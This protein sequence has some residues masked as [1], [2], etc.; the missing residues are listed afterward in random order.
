MYG[1]SKSVEINHIPLCGTAVQGGGR[2][3]VSQSVLAILGISLCLLDNKCFWT[4]EMRWCKTTAARSLQGSMTSEKCC[5]R[6]RTT[7]NKICIGLFRVINVCEHYITPPISP[8]KVCKLW[9]SSS[10]VC[11]KQQFSR[12][13]FSECRSRGVRATCAHSPLTCASVVCRRRRA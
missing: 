4:I 5:L 11:A 1:S 3:A 2:T 9:P 8:K 12:E 13:S 7:T 6:H 10:V